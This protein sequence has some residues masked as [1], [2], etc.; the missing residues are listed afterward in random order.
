MEAVAPSP[1]TSTRPMRA[2]T[3]SALSL[4]LVVIA[5][6][7][8]AGPGINLRWN[9]CLGDLGVLNKNFACNT[10]SGS[11][12]LVCS[13]VPPVDILQASGQEITIDLVTEGAS[14]PEWWAFKNVGTCR[15]AALAMNL[16]ISPAAVNCTDWANGAGVGAIGAYKIGA[17]TPN[18]ARITAASAVAVEAIAFLSAGTEY[19]SANF[20]INHSKTVGTG[21]C[22]GCTAGAC[23]VFRAD[24]VTTP[25]AIHDVLI[26]GA[27]N[28]TDSFFATWQGGTVTSIGGVTLP[29]PYPVP[30]RHSSWGALRSLYR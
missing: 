28:G 19:F 14:L 5:S 11:D 27:T 15:Q 13:F 25:V 23:I 26:T 18:S 1:A 30:T 17:L 2:I 8:H 10:N 6:T 22:A 16:A 20:T 21:S 3:R 4:A 7:A 24:K 12:V 29:C 9:A